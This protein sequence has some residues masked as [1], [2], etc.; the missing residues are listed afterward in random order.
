MLLIYLVYRVTERKNIVITGAS[1]GLGD[2]MA[3]EWGA[4]N[5]QLGLCARRT[6]RLASLQNDLLEKSPEDKVSV[7]SLDVNDHEQ[8]FK[9]F[10]EF[11][12]DFGQ[13]DR[14]VVNAGI[15]LGASVGTGY[16][17]A[18]VK[19]AETNFVS[20]L[21][22]C[23]AAL[24]IFREQNAGHLV[25]ISSVSAFRGFKGALTS[26][27]ASKAGIAALAE[28]IR[29]DLQ[30]T[31]IT[32]TTL[33]PGYIDSDINRGIKNRPFVVDTETG[34]K[35]MVALIEREVQDATVPQWPWSMVGLL[36]RNLPLGLVSKMS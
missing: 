9:V 28:G 11:K 29:V 15:G 36:M 19:T 25:V 4:M 33:F 5:R 16:W 8:V 31:P 6:D 14:I 24:E 18:N 32:I 34:C 2:G 7:R 21:V 27:A 12:S 35:K 3:R 10:K 26:Y 22:Q 23:E 17:E 1:S 13:I 20:A 30:N